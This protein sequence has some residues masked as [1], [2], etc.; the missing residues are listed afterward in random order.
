MSIRRRG[1]GSRRSADTWR[2]KSWYNVVVPSYVLPETVE[3][4]IIGETVAETPEHLIGRN[5]QTTMLELT[6]D[7]NKMHIKLKFK[8]T[9]VESKNALTVFNGHEMSRDYIKSQ[10]RRHQSKID[11]IHNGRTKDGA[12]L[13]I[14]MTITTPHRCSNSHKLSF[15]KLAEVFLNEKLASYTFEEIT[16]KLFDG[17]LS[18]EFTEKANVIFPTKKTDIQKSKVLE[19]PATLAS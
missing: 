11:L 19:L 2:Y 4:R 15:R 13:R 5:V 9:K 18:D 8:I 16:P 14:T 1:G 3:Q 17:S 7:F 6:Q 12:K 10:I